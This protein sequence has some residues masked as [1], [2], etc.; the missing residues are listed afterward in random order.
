MKIINCC[1][2]GPGAFID[3][4]LKKIATKNNP[5]KK[6]LE[7]HGGVPNSRQN[8]FNGNDSYPIIQK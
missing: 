3:L 4:C 8:Q 6:K 1:E 5:W 7:R 2:Y